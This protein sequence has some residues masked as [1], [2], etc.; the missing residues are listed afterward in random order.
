IAIEERID[1][2]EPG[3][4]IRWRDWL[5]ISV[6]LDRHVRSEGAK[7]ARLREPGHPWGRPVAAV[8][9]LEL[10]TWWEGRGGRHPLPLRHIARKLGISES[11][12][13]KHLHA[14]RSAGKVDDQARD[15]A[16]AT[17]PLH[18]GGRKP[19]PLDDDALRA[20]WEARKSPAVIARN[21]QVSRSR[22]KARLRELGLL[23]QAKVGE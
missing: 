4:A 23:R 2:T 1:T 11:T 9:P 18:Q 21:L 8:N 22:V 6:Q 3:G 17:R 7:V 20:Q 12:A 10:L 5:D 16:L 19:N 14:L 13:R 15:R